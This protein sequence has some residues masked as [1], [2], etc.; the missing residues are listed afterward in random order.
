MCPLSRGCQKERALV[1]EAQQQSAPVLFVHFT[2]MQHWI[3]SPVCNTGYHH[4]C[5]TLDVFTGVGTALAAE[6]E[7][8][9]AA[10][11]ASVGPKPKQAVS[12]DNVADY[13]ASVL[14]TCVLDMPYS[15]DNIGKGV[16]F[17]VN[18][19]IGFRV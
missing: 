10:C 17:G 3:S 1:S 5:A 19:L 12:M 9:E 13:K 11:A 15:D 6:A 16:C 4:R 18:D 2:G 14:K 8:R 7:D